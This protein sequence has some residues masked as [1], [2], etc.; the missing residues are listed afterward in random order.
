MHRGVPKGCSELL[1]SGATVLVEDFYTLGHLRPE[2]TKERDRG[3][4]KIWAESEKKR[5]KDGGIE[6]RGGVGGGERRQRR[7]KKQAQP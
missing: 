5:D 1:P 4:G 6:R 3:G 7:Q 2:K